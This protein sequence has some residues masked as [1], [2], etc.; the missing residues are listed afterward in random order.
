[1][2]YCVHFYTYQSKLYKVLRQWLM[3]KE[4]YKEN[5]KTQDKI[6]LFTELVVRRN[7][8]WNKLRLDILAAIPYLYKI[9]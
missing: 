4:Q 9:H 3:I 7:P 6:L 8:L 2:K 5:Y 1:M